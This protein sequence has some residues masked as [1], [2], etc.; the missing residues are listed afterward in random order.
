MFEIQKNIM[1]YKQIIIMK[2][3]CSF[4]CF[5]FVATS[6]FAQPDTND[7][8]RLPA[9]T[10][11][12]DFQLSNFQLPEF[13]RKAL[14]MS[15]G[16]SNVFSAGS[17]YEFLQYPDDRPDRENNS[18]GFWNSF[19]LESRFDFSDIHY[20][21]RHQRET[22]ISSNFRFNSDYS[23]ARLNDQNPGRDNRLEI[24]PQV[25]YRQINRR[26]LNESLLIDYSPSVAYYLNARRTT[27]RRKDDQDDKD[28][29][30]SQILTAGI[31]LGI[32]HG[33][34][35][36]VGDARHAIHIFDALARRGVTSASKT[37][38]EI[39]R[40]A[41]FIAELKNKRHLDARHRKI[42]EMEA[43]DSFLIA[44]GH[45]DTLNMAYFTTLEDFWIH[46][47]VNRLS[48]WRWLFYTAPGYE[49]KPI[50]AKTLLDRD[51]THHLYQ[52]DNIIHTRLGINF[53]YEKPIS[54]FWQNSFSSSVEYRQRN[55][56]LVDNN[57][58]R[59]VKNIRYFFESDFYLNLR[60]RFSYFPTTRTSAYATYRLLYRFDEFARLRR[61]FDFSTRN[62]GVEIGAGASYFLSPQLQLRLDTFLNYGNNKIDGYYHNSWISRRKEHGSGFRFQLYLSVNYTF[63]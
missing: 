59:E 56:R 34:I 15:H 28:I 53:T 26:Y 55:F 63:Y 4:L 52:D 2:P 40:F 29:R 1:K 45:R 47:N 35:E 62:F 51:I 31:T 17:G 10:V 37:S 19:I 8:A 11:N 33:R 22:Y 21:R 5:L 57:K 44:N 25:S 14:T 13:R 54:L 9:T 3:S 20:T 38:D 24:I 42:Y 46:G 50:S 43:L 32:G 58:L 60:Q 36:P 30:F 48:G 6:V 18:R 61:E 27:F 39:N 12:P 16:L 41:E 23:R 49:F 7:Y